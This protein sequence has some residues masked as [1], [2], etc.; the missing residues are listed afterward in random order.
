VKKAMN[1]W[2]RDHR[3][4]LFRLGALLVFY[5]AATACASELRQTPA[6]PVHSYRGLNESTIVWPR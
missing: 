5:L 4:S 2:L 1:R 3:V 6:P